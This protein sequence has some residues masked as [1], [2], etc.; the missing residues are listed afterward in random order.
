MLLTES[1]PMFSLYVTAVSLGLLGSSHCIGMCGG[2]TSALSVSLKENSRWQTALLM[3][4]Y[5]IGR[6]G[7]YALAGVLL[8]TVGWYLG[9]MSPILFSALRWLAGLMLVA[10]GLYIS[11]WWRGLVQLERL[12]GHLWKRIQP[13]T[14]RLLPVRHLPGAIALG[15]LW[16]WLPCGLVYSTLIWSASQSSALQSALL[17]SLFGLGTLPAVLL[18]GV[19][20]SQLTAL[21]QA[22]ITRQL[23]GVFMILFGVWT[24][25]GPHQM[26]L[27]S[28]FSFGHHAM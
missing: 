3:L 12:G 10:M 27:M 14:H 4:G 5:H 23:A 21:V 8:G 19:F 2:I 1:T 18:T 16:G 28:L 13:S 11:G 22:G 15:C 26:W 9:D 17:M 24:C 25:P 6:I 7:S 20:A